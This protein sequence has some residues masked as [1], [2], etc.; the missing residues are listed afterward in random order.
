[1]EEQK[2]QTI[3]ELA[4]AGRSAKEIIEATNYPK[5]TV[6][7]VLKVFL[8]SGRVM[9]SKHKPRRDRI[10]TATFVANLKKSIHRNPTTSL[11]T[12]A[13]RRNVSDSTVRRAV[14]VNLGYKSR[15]RGVKHLLTDKMKATRVERSK[16]IL[17]SLKHTGGFIQFFSDEKMFT[18]D[19]SSNSRNDRWIS[20]SA[21]DVQPVMRTKHP[22]SAMCLGVISSEGDVMTPYFFGAKEKVNTAVYCDVLERVVI[23]WMN[24]KASGRQYTFQQ[25]SAPAHK[26]KTTLALL[27]DK[28]PHFW[29]PQEWPSNS[30]DLNPCDYYLWGRLEREA[31]S[32][33]HSNVASLKAAVTKEAAK[34]DRA[35]VATAVKA[36]RARVELCIENLGNHIE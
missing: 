29:T 25:D 9:R 11:A 4:R 20:A 33:P 10:R 2:R 18:V 7:R 26:A 13:K 36:F 16:K 14:K 5:A 24:S 17:S 1:M 27:A 15:A 32:T 6:Y 22:A 8:E 28:V 19:A 35:E 34:L 21:G 31:C 12:L 30:P 3:V 23:P